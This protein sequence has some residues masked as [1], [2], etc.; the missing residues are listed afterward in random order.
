MMF[1]VRFQGCRRAIIDLAKIQGQ[2]T[3]F[4]FAVV[5]L[6]KLKRQSSAASLLIGHIGK[7]QHLNNGT[8][9]AMTTSFRLE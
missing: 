6:L 4:L 2:A 1:H 9:K 3:E 8:K 7:E 5:V